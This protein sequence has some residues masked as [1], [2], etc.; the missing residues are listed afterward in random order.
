MAGHAAKVFMPACELASRSSKS[1]TIAKRNR[2]PITKRI[3]EIVFP[4]VVLSPIRKLSIWSTKWLARSIGFSRS[5]FPPGSTQL[6]ASGAAPQ[7]NMGVCDIH[8]IYESLCID[9]SAACAIL[10]KRSTAKRPRL[11]YEAT[12]AQLTAPSNRSLIGMKTSWPVLRSSANP[13]RV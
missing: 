6:P 8:H 9:F 7:P 3:E 11:L 13:I 2:D 5:N 4:L 10:Q 12:T 1:F